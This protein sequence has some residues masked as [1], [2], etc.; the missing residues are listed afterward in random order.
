MKEDDTPIPIF[1]LFHTIFAFFRQHG[2]VILRLL[3]SP[4]DRPILELS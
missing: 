3:R 1:L 4:P 2:G